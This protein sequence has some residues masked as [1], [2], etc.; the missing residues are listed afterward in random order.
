MRRENLDSVCVCVCFP[1][2]V[3]LFSSFLLGGGGVGD[4]CPCFSLSLFL[5]RGCVLI[6]LNFLFWEGAVFKGPTKLVVVLLVS[7]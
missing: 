4:V 6:F 2:F 7:L 3:L 5:L 1:F